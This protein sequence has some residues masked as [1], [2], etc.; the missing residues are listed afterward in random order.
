LGIFLSNKDRK[1]RGM[2]SGLLT[3]ACIIIIII[4]SLYLLLNAHAVAYYEVDYPKY[5]LE[6]LRK[7]F[8]L[9]DGVLL[10]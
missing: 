3:C 5:N 2:P 4:I 6:E 8:S 10:I 7:T 1:L 9:N